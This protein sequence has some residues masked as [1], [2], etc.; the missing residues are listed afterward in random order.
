MAVI[1]AVSVAVSGAA[2]VDIRVSRISAVAAQAQEH[3]TGWLSSSERARVAAISSAARRTE[4]VAGRWQLRRLLAERHGG[5]AQRDWPLSAGRDEPPRL[6]DPPLSSACFFSLSHSG[7]WLACA[8]ADCAVGIDIEVTARQKSFAAIID[9]I[10]TSNERALF[11]RLDESEARRY[12]W[13][14]WTAKEACLK[15]HGDGANVPALQAIDTSV[16]AQTAS[17]HAWVWSGA[18]LTMALA[19][20]GAPRE[21]WCPRLDA[22]DDKITFPA[23]VAWPVAVVLPT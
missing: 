23:A 16:G 19:M 15:L 14:L 3:G 1:G 18:P 6:I 2:G 4:F 21:G 10:G 11:N 20:K 5:D 22:L 7:E 12:F 9:V 8:V 13:C 17:D